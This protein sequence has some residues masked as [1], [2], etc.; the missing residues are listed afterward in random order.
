MSPT[1]AL[2]A[3]DPE[4]FGL[5]YDE[6]AGRLHAYCRVMVG[7]EAPD[8]VRDTFVAAARQSGTVPDDET[9]PE[10]LYALARDECLRRGALLRTAPA[11]PSA[12][13][14]HR[15]VARLRPEHREVLALSGTFETD[16]IAR[17]IGLALDTTKLLIRVAQR[18]MDDAAAS[19]LGGRAVHD[20]TMLAALG[21]GRLYTLVGEPDEPPAELR[22][23]VLT[24]CAAADALLFDQDGTPIRLDGPAD[25]PTHPI[26]QITAGETAAPRRGR[27]AAST[28]ESTT[29]PDHAVPTAGEP[30]ERKPGR[31]AAEPTGR[32]SRGTRRA[33]HGTG[34]RVRT[35]RQAFVH[36]R[37]DGLL[38][39]LG[40]AA[41]VAAAAGALALWPTPN[42]G[43][44]A[45]MDGTSLLL[46]PGASASRVLGPPVTAGD[47]PQNATTADAKKTPSPSP[48]KPSVSAT[49]QDAR[50]TPAPNP[51]TT[52]TPTTSATT[53]TPSPVSSP[54]ATPTPTPGTPTPTP[55]SP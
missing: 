12:E 44:G 22:T 18:R 33:S 24:S 28:P 45:N 32:G 27:H 19:V 35:K 46:H 1:E 47:P 52:P 40:L 8:A 48:S 11:D 36:R 9:L 53:P 2:R 37:H 54:L 15:A 16:S 5:L 43:D 21:T 10:W 55:G 49:P 29:A 30:A 4:V 17:V 51:T 3:G 7:D 26:R 23:R 39:T 42:H 13:P 20:E 50:V 25:A 41:C 38:E 6:H 31:H 34:T 14:L